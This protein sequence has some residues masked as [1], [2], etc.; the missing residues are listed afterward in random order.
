M[1]F[2]KKASHLR[3]CCEVLGTLKKPQEH[4]GSVLTIDL[5]ICRSTDVDRI[6]TS[7]ITWFHKILCHG[8]QSRQVRPR[9]SFEALDLISRED[10]GISTQPQNL[11]EARGKSYVINSSNQTPEVR[12][13]ST[14]LNFVA[15]PVLPSSPPF[16]RRLR[17]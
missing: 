16:T 8:N 9:N 10:N 3:N 2:I 7:M 5:E 11:K 17:I 12:I 14:P 1:I 6:F 15:K 4:E 13:A